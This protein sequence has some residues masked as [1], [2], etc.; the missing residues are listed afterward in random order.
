MRSLRRLGRSG[1]GS[2]FSRETA[3]MGRRTAEGVWY[4]ERLRA[5][6]ASRSPQPQGDTRGS[7]AKQQ[8]QAA[9]RGR[10]TPAPGD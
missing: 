9:G 1:K 7:S 2:S 4:K 10:L 5:Y 6:P 8:Q 3:W